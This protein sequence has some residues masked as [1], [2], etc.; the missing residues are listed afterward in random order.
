[1]TT[2]SPTMDAAFHAMAAHLHRGAPW[3]YYWAK[4]PS[5]EKQTF[6]FETGRP[7]PPMP[8]EWAGADLYFAVNPTTARGT[9]YTRAKLGDI[10]AINCFFAEFDDKDWG[11]R[12]AINQHIAQLDPPPSAL[13]SSGGGIHAYWLLRNTATVTDANREDVRA[14]EKRWNAH[15]GGSKSVNDI[16]RVLR[17]PGSFNFKYS[18]PRPVELV[19][20]DLAEQYDLVALLQMLPGQS[21]TPTPTPA[22][23]DLDDAALIDS[24]RR[25]KQGAEFDRL[26]A[27]DLTAHA[28]DHSA[29]DHALLRILAFWTRRDVGRMLQLFKASQLYDPATRT[30]KHA[31]YPG[32]L[33]KT[34]ESAAASCAKVYDPPQRDQAAIDA[35]AAAVGSNAPAQPAQPQAGQ[36]LRSGKRQIAVSADL[37]KMRD[38]ALAVLRDA[39]MPPKLFVS[40]GQLAE[41]DWNDAAP[42]IRSVS[43]PALL[44]HLVDDADWLDGKGQRGAAP[45]KDAAD[46]LLALPDLPFPRLT[47]IAQAPIFAPDGTLCSAPGY[48]AAAESWIDHALHIPDTTPDATAVRTAI[49][50][51]RDELLGDFPFADDASRAHAIAL[52]LLPFCRAMIDGPTPLHLVDA[53]LRGAGKGLLVGACT[54][55]ALGR[56]ADSQPLSGDEES[57][58]KMLLSVLLEGRPIVN[59]DNMTRL[60]SDSLALALTQHT[61]TDRALGLN[62]TRSAPIRCVWV[63]TGNNLS[64]SEDIA[65]RCCFIRLQPTME[66]PE[67]R[68]GFKHANLLVWAAEHR[69]DLVWA[70]LVIIRNWIAQ[71]RPTAGAV[72]GSYSSW[73]DVMGGILHASGI[74]GFLEN[75]MQIAAA[76]SPERAAMRILFTEWWK[77]HQSKTVFLD[78]LVSLALPEALNPAA[79]VPPWQ[80]ILEDLLDTKDLRTARRSLGNHLRTWAGRVLE[81]DGAGAVVLRVGNRAKKGMPWNLEVVR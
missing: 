17:V 7:L 12:A 8:Q 28:G 47:A 54:L 77:A 66:T 9:H 64:V 81:I 31:D 5:G 27:G 48:A 32:Y 59:L 62:A 79:G 36:P 71:G 40:A 67:L 49:S 23:V 60:D 52:G 10:A 4:L 80:G 53:P 22:P 19:Y 74:P 1:M 33:L 41:V 39:N 46:L 37:R 42:K 14:I 72:K 13:V 65:R 69:A 26:M 58:R 75:E 18:P 24:I 35:A 2:A 56:P 38:V 21:T 3:A 78:D 20:C 34:A 43:R 57:V 63:A 61:F 70:A 25:S 51:W 68:T 29:A 30:A 15:V 16:A 11:E 73:A 45:P 44:N 76:K 55:P 50:L 6:W